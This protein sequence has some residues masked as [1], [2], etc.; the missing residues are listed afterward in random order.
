MQNLKNTL[1]INA[2]D[3]VVLSSQRGLAE[4]DLSHTLI[5]A[6][7][8]V[9]ITE[10]SADL[11]QYAGK[12]QLLFQ[13][14]GTDLAE[15][16]AQFPI[17]SLRPL[18]VS[19]QVRADSAAK[20]ST[21][22]ARGLKAVIRLNAGTHI[23]ETPAAVSRVSGTIDAQTQSVGIVASIADPYKKASPGKRPPMIRGT[24]VEV[25]L[26]GTA[27]PDQVVV[28]AEAV[29]QGKVYVLSDDSRLVIKPVKVSFTQGGFSVIAKGLNPGTQLVVTDLIPAV[30]GML[31][32]PMEDKKTQMKLVA[33]ATGIVTGDNSGSSSLDQK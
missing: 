8:D 13:G 33:E 29:R 21:Q 9:R 14:D 32:K 1:S 27:I 11:A 2:A 20:S 28:P 25:E 3:R 6:P 12:G 5:R 17:G 26:K 15:V 16:E 22:A 18:I 4:L 23:V 7:Y 10:V 19:R 31:L 30:E 24:F